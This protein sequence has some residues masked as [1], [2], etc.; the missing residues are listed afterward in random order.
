MSPPGEEEGEAKDGENLPV[1][2][3]Q[4]QR[5]GLVSEDSEPESHRDGLVTDPSLPAEAPEHPPGDG[6][7]VR[8][9]LQAGTVS[10]HLARQVMYGTC[11]ILR[12][13]YDVLYM[14]TIVSF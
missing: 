8:L 6:L 3:G 1:T 2:V 7:L 12:V 5:H 4:S 9:P 10:G 13:V 14:D 11:C